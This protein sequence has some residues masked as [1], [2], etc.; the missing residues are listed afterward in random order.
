MG[1]NLKSFKKFDGK[2]HFLLCFAIIDSIGVDWLLLN[3][4]SRY[5]KL[6]QCGKK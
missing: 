5:S 2:F 1:S 6:L 4:I 3:E